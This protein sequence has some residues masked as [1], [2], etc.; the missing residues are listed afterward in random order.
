MSTTKRRDSKNRIL[1]RGEGQLKD[2]RYYYRYTDSEGKRHEVYSW[3]LV[4]TDTV[5]AGM[6]IDDPLREKEK[7][8]RRDMD[9]GIR[10]SAADITVNELFRRWCEGQRGRLD[11]G[12]IEGYRLLYNKHFS[13]QLGRK[14]LKNIRHS[15]IE[16]RYCDM[17]ELDGLSVST[18]LSLNSAV[19]Q[20]FQMALQDGLVRVN[21]AVGATKLISSIHSGETKVKGALTAEQQSDGTYTL[22]ANFSSAG[23]W[24]V[25]R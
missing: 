5:P 15:D 2:G 12:T 8:I 6:A 9:D 16:R 18:V 20:A 13:E 7:A 14:K 22:R 17:V 19:G 3:R 10:S 4:S 1:Q 23:K 21:P 11:P 24:R 25:I